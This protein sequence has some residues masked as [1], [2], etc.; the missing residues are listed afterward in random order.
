MRLQLFGLAP[1]VAAGVL[2]VGA[3]CAGNSSNV[4]TFL[5]GGTGGAGGVKSGNAA[6]ASVVFGTVQN[7]SGAYVGCYKILDAVAAKATDR[8]IAH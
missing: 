5:R 6:L 2:L 1:D 7:A 4:T 3:V 8:D